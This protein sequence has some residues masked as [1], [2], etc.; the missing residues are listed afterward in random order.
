VIASVL[1]DEIALV[2]LAGKETNL[3]RLRLITRRYRADVVAAARAA[4]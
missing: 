1:D 2:I 4:V 3:G